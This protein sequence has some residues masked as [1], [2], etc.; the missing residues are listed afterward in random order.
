MKYESIPYVV[1]AFQAPAQLQ[2]YMATDNGTP[3][4]NRIVKAGEWVVYRSGLVVAILTTEAFNKAY[5]PVH[6][7][8][9][10]FFNMPNGVR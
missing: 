4:E 10:A 2:V 3:T 9:P 1:E 6:H 7:C 8:T 5:R